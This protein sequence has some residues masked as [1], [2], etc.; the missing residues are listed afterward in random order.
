MRGIQFLR[1]RRGGAGTAVDIRMVLLGERAIGR[2][3][4]RDGASPVQAEGGVMVG[5][6]V[7]QPREVRKI[8][9]RRPAADFFWMERGQLVRTSSWLTMNSRTGRPRSPPRAVFFKGEGFE[10]VEFR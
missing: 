1:A 10:S 8:S 9:R 4:L 2:T 7:F 6:E 5:N 3:D